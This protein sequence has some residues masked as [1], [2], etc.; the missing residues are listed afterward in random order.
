MLYSITF[1]HKKQNY[2]SMQRLFYFGILLFMMACSVKPPL[3][4]DVD[5]IPTLPDYAN[6]DH[7]AALPEKRDSADLVPETH[8]QN[9]QS[10]AVVDVF[11]LHPTTYTGD[12]GHK[13]WNAPIDDAILNKKTDAGTIRNQ[14]SIFN[15][16]GRVY[17][18]RYRQAHIQAYYD[19]TPKDIAKQAFDL[20]YTDIK[21]AFEYYL[22]NYNEGRPIIIAAHS[23]GTTHAGK[24]IKEFFDGKPLQ[25]K[26]V[27]AYLVG[28][29]V[30]KNYFQQI[31]PCKTPDETSCFCTWRTYREGHIPKNRVIGDSIAVTNPLTWTTDTKLAPQSLNKGAVLRK[32]HK[33]FVPN[34]VSAQINK[35]ILWV[36]KPQFPGSFLLVTPNYHIADFNLFYANVRANV[37]ERT[38]SYLVNAH[39]K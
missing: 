34:L 15:E 20:A 21:V 27:V 24:L 11:F 5:K 6:A 29:P 23:Q 35:G 31:K 12:K 32:F 38:D 14:A 18:P 22:E 19:R 13:N 10:E 8:L 26:L 37:A 16:I 36:N 17:A 1:K 3:S 9:L 39:L 30:P 25:N 28:M 4:Y 7:W 2:K 33:G